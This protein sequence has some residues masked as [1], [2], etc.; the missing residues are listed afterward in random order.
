MRPETEKIGAI[1]IG[2]C[3]AGA[4]FGAV[5]SDWQ[6]AALIVTLI[7]MGLAAAWF[8]VTQ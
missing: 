5:T 8:A 7:C 6:N 1:G 2:T 3:I 4:I